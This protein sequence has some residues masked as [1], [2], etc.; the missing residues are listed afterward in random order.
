[1][2]LHKSFCTW[3]ETS[4]KIKRQPLNERRYFSSDM[5]NKRFISKIYEELIQLNIVKTILPKEK[6]KN[7]Q[8]IWTDIFP[9]KTSISQRFHKNMLNIIHYQVIT[10]EKP[11]W[12]ITLHSSELLIIKKTDKY[13][14]EHREKGIFVY[15]LLIGI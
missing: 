3:K 9:K 2:E 1:M 4:N 13:W 5:T 8:R 15:A 7:G 10:C 14:W 6:K 11:Q 12:G